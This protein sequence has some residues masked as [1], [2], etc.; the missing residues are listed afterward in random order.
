MA[1][2]KKNWYNIGDLE[3]NDNN[4]MVN[5]TTM[6][7]FEKRINDEFK[8]V[9]EKIQVTFGTGKLNSTDFKS[10]S[11]YWVKIGTLVLVQIE[12]LQSAENKS[13]E[14]II[15]TELPEAKNTKY[16]LLNDSS[17]SPNSVQSR[18][19]GTNFQIWYD[20]LQQNL[21]Y[22]DTFWYEAKE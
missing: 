2:Q 12:L 9:N 21:A 10:G 13:G 7:D 22:F 16:T 19:N 6:N 4:S 20:S 1:Y 14:T 18:I 8:S 15:F 11:C 17:G 5:K 3:A